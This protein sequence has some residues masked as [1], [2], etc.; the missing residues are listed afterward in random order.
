MKLQKAL[1][2]SVG[3]V[4]FLGVLFTATW[5]QAQADCRDLRVMS[6]NIRYGTAADGDNHWSKR[7]EL[8]FEVISGHKPDIVGLQ[9]ALRFQIDEILA[10][11]PGYTFLGV[12]RD[13]G[14]TQGEHA[15]ILF[16]T[17]RLTAVQ[18]GNFWFSETPDKPGSKHWGNQITR[19]C[20]WAQFKTREGDR[21]FYFYNLHLDHR[22]QPSREKSAELLLRKIAERES[23]DPVILTGD[24]NAGETN[25]AVVRIKE[26]FRDTFRVIHPDADQVAT[27]N[28]FKE[29]PS[30]GDKIDFVFAS[31]SLEVKEAAIVRDNRDGRY[32]SDH[33][34]VT[35]T[36]CLP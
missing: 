23:Q 28:G 26:Q 17:D 30:G 7:K 33:F 4:L 8:V 20:T 27:F 13:D 21:R 5:V 1:R 31:P 32:P 22:S 2:V 35:A 16:R 6:F 14:Q 25:P 11:V 12:G 34:P 24:F 18:H 36:I 10:A 3:L 29:P 9:E 15:A 19:I